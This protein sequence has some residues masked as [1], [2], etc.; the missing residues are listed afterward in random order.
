MFWFKMAREKQIGFGFSQRNMRTGEVE[1]VG[2]VRAPALLEEMTSGDTGFYSRGIDGINLDNPSV[3][4]TEMQ[5]RAA[6]EILMQQR[7]DEYMAEKRAQE[8]KPKYKYFLKEIRRRR[9]SLKPSDHSDAKKR[10]LEEVFPGQFSKQ[11]LSQYT[12]AQLGRI[13]LKLRGYALGRDD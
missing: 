13:F 7:I 4:E 3:E 11:D 8:M 9:I 2:A 1:R 12:P 5:Q 10:L 6:D